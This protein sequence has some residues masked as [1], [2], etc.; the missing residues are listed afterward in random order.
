MVYVYSGWLYPH[1]VSQLQ[2]SGAG[3]K[4]GSA[5]VFPGLPLDKTVLHCITQHGGIWCRIFLCSGRCLT[6]Q[7]IF[8]GWFVLSVYR[9]T[10][11]IVDLPFSGE[12]AHVKRA[13]GVFELILERFLVM[14]QAFFAGINEF[15]HHT[16]HNRGILVLVA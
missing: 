11:V 4:K 12:K 2:N 6:E 15:C 8:C 14:V 3:K 7:R 16:S 13:F 10:G 9:K 5:R 1:A